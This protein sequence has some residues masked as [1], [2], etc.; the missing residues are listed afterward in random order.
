MKHG[1]HARRRHRST[2]SQALVRQATEAAETDAG[3]PAL[4]ES[5]RGVLI[6]AA[7]GNALGLPV[8][9][10]SRAELLRHYPNGVREIDPGERTAPWDDD[11]AQTVFL[12]DC[13][14]ERG[15]FDADDF[16]SRLVAWA[17][18]GGRGIG[19]LTA[20]VVDRLIAGASPTRAA[21]DAWEASAST[22]AGN[23]AVMRFAPVA[24][25]YRL[26]PEQLIDAAE[27]Q[28]R[29]THHDGLCVWST[30]AVTVGLARKLSGAVTD[31]NELADAIKADGAPEEV[32]DAVRSVAG[33]S[34]ADFELDDPAAMGYTLKA[35][36]VGLWCLEQNGTFEDRLV[37]VIACGGDADTNGAVAGAVLGA[38]GES[39]IPHRWLASIAG[40]DD[41]RRRADELRGQAE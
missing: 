20:D 32:A 2:R 9:G 13:L 22:P 18:A 19:V 28:C 41:L 25:R 30:I 34:L 8:E 37:E 17:R 16:A 27:A 11:V 24:L 5:Y 3:A 21:R 40:A 10:W 23:G 38:A 14:I 15:R 7:V 39:A 26:D 29:V 6:G 12:A 31:P 35:M 4:R 33:A 36:Q 1:F